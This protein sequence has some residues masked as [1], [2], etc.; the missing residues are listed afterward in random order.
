MLGATGCARA[1]FR[2]GWRKESSSDKDDYCV[3]RLVEAIR[4]KEVAEYA[5]VST[6]LK[7]NIA[8]ITKA[9]SA[10]NKGMEGGFL[11]SKGAQVLKHLAMSNNGLTNYDDLMK[12]DVQT[13][14]QFVFL[15]WVLKTGC[16]V[17]I[18]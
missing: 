2:C 5:K 13:H 14:V 4:E 16:S 8:A 9:I 11:Q 6:E 7:T 1:H 12:A 17:C 10:I 3:E 18:A 15:H